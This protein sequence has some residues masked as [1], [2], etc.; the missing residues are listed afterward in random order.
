MSDAHWW[1]NL[2]VG[3]RFDELP[4]AA[5]DRGASSMAVRL[6]ELAVEHAAGPDFPRLQSQL[7]RLREELDERD[8]GCPNCSARGAYED[9]ETGWCKVC[10]FDLYSTAEETNRAES[11]PPVERG[12]DD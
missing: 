11:P 10:H 2:P 12:A 5:R 8:D 3:T 7:E 6:L 9:D 4:A 1:E